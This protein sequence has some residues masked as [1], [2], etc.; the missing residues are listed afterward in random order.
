MWLG[1]FDAF[2][3]NFWT[4]RSPCDVESRHTSH[5]VFNTAELPIG[6]AQV[7]Q[8]LSVRQWLKARILSHVG[9]LQRSVPHL[10]RPP[11]AYRTYTDIRRSPKLPPTFQARTIRT[12][13]QVQ[14]QDSSSL[15]LDERTTEA[16]LLERI[17]RK[18]RSRTRRDHS[19]RCHP[20]SRTPRPEQNA[21]P[22]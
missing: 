12:S 1:A 8:C 5:H 22:L 6:L 7:K 11:T 18:T 3:P 15:S 9:E 14:R 20:S 2:A 10:H 19:G 21:K 16:C 17:P 4:L 13:L